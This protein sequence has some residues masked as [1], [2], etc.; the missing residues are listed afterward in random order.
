MKIKAI[1]TGSTGMVGEGVLLECMA[2]PDVE[3]VLIINRRPLGIS[4]PKLQE[5][6]HADFFNLSAIESQLRGYNACYFCAGV[7][8]VGMSQE[9][10]KKF[11]YD[12]TIAFAKTLARQNPDMTFCYVTGM[13]TD[14]TEQGRVFWARVKGATENELM[15]IFKNAY[16]FRPGFMRHVRGQK[17]LKW[18]YNALAWTYWIGIVVWPS[19]FLTLK[20]VAKAMVAVTLK[21]Y[22]T[23]VMEVRDIAKAAAL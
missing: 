6:I 10:Y 21:G 22:E 11:T 16:M 7:S 15:R 14:S 8:S 2:N 1:I 20:Q 3:K 23:K 19:A 18:Y 17:N 9:D 4:H 12:M 13:H 5:I